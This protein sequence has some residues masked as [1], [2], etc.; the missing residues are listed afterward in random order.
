MAAIQTQDNTP[1]THIP[2]VRHLFLS[3]LVDWIFFF[4]CNPPQNCLLRLFQPHKKEVLKGNTLT[5]LCILCYGF[6]VTSRCVWISGCQKHLCNSWG[7]KNLFL[8]EIQMDGWRE[9][10]R[11]LKHRPA[12]LSSFLVSTNQSCAF[13]I[14]FAR[15]VSYIALHLIPL[16][17]TRFIFF[18]LTSALFSPSLS[19]LPTS[20]CLSIFLSQSVL[21]FLLLTSSLSWFKLI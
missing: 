11:W 1:H 12:L 21:C 3:S 18:L 17:L 2:S 20:K 19:S 6:S 13:I 14:I 16:L 10:E 9:K 7:W 15:S 5:Y 8:L 4:F